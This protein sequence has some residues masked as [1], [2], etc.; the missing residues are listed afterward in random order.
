MENI[1]NSVEYIEQKIVPA[2]IKPELGIILGSGLGNFAAEIKGITI[3]YSEIPGFKPS[4]IKGHSGNLIIG[5]FY[6]KKILA[7][8][9]RLHFYEGYSLQ[10]V[11]YPVRVMKFLGIKK[12]II[13]NAAGGI[14]TAFTP[15]DFMIIEDHINL[16][17][18]NPLLGVNPDEI[19]PRFPDMSEPYNKNLIKLAEK[20]AKTLNINIKKGV[21]AGVTGPNYETPAEI[22]MFRMLGADAIGMST[23]PEVIAARHAGL[24]TLGISFITNMAAGIL[25]KNLCHQEVID[26]AASVEDKLYAFL[27]EIIININ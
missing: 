20:T 13:T 26:T 17:G 3:P 24:D 14:N 1:K 22:R 2:G 9:G 6:S 11:I 15:G 18:N 8:Q 27:K 21:Y 16:T 23:V 7:M 12:I 10:D 5:E 19:G 25:N 4:T